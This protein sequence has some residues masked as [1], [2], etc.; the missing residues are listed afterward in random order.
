MTTYAL[1]SP[2]KSPSVAPLAR[3]ACIDGWRINVP[4]E[5]WLIDRIV[6]DAVDGRGGTVFTINLDH[7]AKL[8][9]DAPFRAAYQRATYISADGVPVV[10]MA[11]SE[12]VPLERVTGADLVLPLSR[13]AAAAGVPVHFFGARV[14]VL[15]RAVERLRRD[16]PDLVVAGIE[17]PPM[18]FDPTGEEARA[19][20]ARIAA[21]GAGICFVALGAPKQEIFANAALTASEGVVYLGVGAALDFLAGER[22]RAPRFMQRAGLEWL[23]R[24]FQEPRRM[25][26][27]YMR[28]GLWLLGYVLRLVFG[29]TREVPAPVEIPVETRAGRRVRAIDI[30]VGPAR[31]VAR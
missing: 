27:R 15:E 24:S 13:A 17:A 9:T 22:S 25:L 20:A 6:Q 30:P 16:I 31:E 26:P 3:A 14:D 19:A 11:R 4:D 12:G 18:G 28:S 23:W 8:R 1:R 29:I 21:S 10:M 2:A 5:P 7:L